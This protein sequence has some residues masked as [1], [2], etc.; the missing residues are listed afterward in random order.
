MAIAVHVSDNNLGGGGFKERFAATAFIV[1]K[2]RSLM[3]AHVVMELYFQDVIA[4]ASSS[5]VE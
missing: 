1:M 5:G 2:I 4:D 3:I